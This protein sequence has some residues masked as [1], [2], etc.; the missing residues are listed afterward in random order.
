MK[1]YLKIAVLLLFSGLLAGCEQSLSY[2][3]DVLPILK[4]HCIECHTGAGQGLLKSGLELGSYEGL[5]KGTHYGP[6]VKPG[7]SFT[8]ALVMLVEHRVDAS[9]KMPHNRKSRI[10][11]AQIERLKTWI[12]QGAKNN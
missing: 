7:D 11:Q 6:V 12:D 1:D 2:S 10:D 4:M 8:S 3:H 9:L 5:M